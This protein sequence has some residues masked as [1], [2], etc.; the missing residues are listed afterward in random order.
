MI[1]MIL[2]P[3]ADL[4][5]L[6]TRPEPRT[7]LLCEQIRHHGG[8][9]LALPA[10]Q[11]EPLSAE[12]AAPHDLAVFLSVHAVTHGVQLIQ[13]TPDLKIAAIGR[14]TAAALEAAGLQVHIVPEAGFTSEALLA[15][16]DLDIEQA[17]QVLLV[18]GQGGRQV[19]PEAFAEHGWQVT[20]REVYRRMAPTVP[21]ENI[22]AIE[23][24]WAEEGIDAVTLTS[25]ETLQ[26]LIALLSPRGREL[27]TDTALVA[28]SERILEAAREAGLQGTGILAT[29]ADDE[30]LIG[31]LARWHM[32]A[33]E[34]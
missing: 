8:Q 1:P 2:P 6:V 33:R 30:S 18:R 13:P 16:P 5:I 22:T 4:T 29:A 21:A 34:H 11:I 15:H 7:A 24:H 10:L 27:L 26:N 31:A 28:P 17:R 32:R 12:P 9:A 14:A 19:L 23:Q 3:L 25:V 20:T